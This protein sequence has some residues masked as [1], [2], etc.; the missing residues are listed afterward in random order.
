MKKNSEDY[1]L[2][3]EAALLAWAGKIAHVDRVELTAW[4]IKT[5]NADPNCRAEKQQRYELAEVF[6]GIIK[7]QLAMT[8]GDAGL[9]RLLGKLEAIMDEGD[10]QQVDTR[11]AL[12]G[13]LDK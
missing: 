10:G 11:F 4:V 2:E 6:V 3:D 1:S 8:P 7:R 12:Y 5:L 13:S 9:K